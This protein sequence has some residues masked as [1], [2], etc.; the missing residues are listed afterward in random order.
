MQ[1]PSEAETSP[2]ELRMEDGENNQPAVKKPRATKRTFADTVAAQATFNGLE[3]QQVDGH[4]WAFEEPEIESDS[5][6]DQH[7]ASDDR[8]RVTFSK[9]LRREWCREWRL[10]IIVKY[11]GKH[12]SFNVLNNRLPSIWGL[13][14]RLHLMDIGYNCFV[15]RFENNQD[16]LH[17]LLDGPW[18]IFDNY[19]ATQRWVPEFR[20]K[21]AKM[22]KMAVWVRIPELPV[23][24]FKEKA[25]KDILE[26]VGKPLK[27]DR[28]TMA[29]ERG[30][31]ARA[32]VEVDLNKPLVS[33]VLVGNTA[34]VIEYECLHVVCFGCGVVGHREQECPH[35][36]VVPPEK[37]TVDLNAPP[38]AEKEG[39]PQQNVPSPVPEPVPSKQR[40]GT[41][42]LVSGKSKSVDHRKNHHQNNHKKSAPRKDNN[43]FAALADE[44]ESVEVPRKTKTKGKKSREHGESSKGKSPNLSNSSQNPQPTPPVRQ[45]AVTTS[46]HNTT[47]A[48]GKGRGGPKPTVRNRGR[49]A[50]RKDPTNRGSTPLPSG[51]FSNLKTTGLFQFGES[52][53]PSEDL[54]T[55]N[56]RTVNVGSSSCSTLGEGGR[57]TSS[58]PDP[59]P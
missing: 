45:A 15:A 24:Y 48:N 13:Q 1:P 57:P 20:P 37:A 39:E 4:E 42:M 34:Q 19:L 38:A 27:L 17:V 51:W 11:L 16:Y 9:E 26:N 5:E 44:P 49:E 2:P 53:R 18:K 47:P 55:G 31:F 7:D 58:L 33:E 46:N 36:K 52:H 22:S 12:I 25:I 56:Q 59:S 28:T 8:P 41:W 3:N 14:G 30:K 10:A 29:R 43:R 23:E 6:M 54:S 32:A 50:G 21:T 40:Y 35:V